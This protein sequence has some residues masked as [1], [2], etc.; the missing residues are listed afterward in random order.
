MEIFLDQ[1]FRRSLFKQWKDYYAKYEPIICSNL[2]LYANE[3]LFRVNNYNNAHVSFL[4]ELRARKETFLLFTKICT[5]A[6]NDLEKNGKKIN[7]NLEVQDLLNPLFLYFLDDLLNRVNINPENVNFE[8]LENEEINEENKSIVLWKLKALSEIWFK[9]SIDDLFSWYS[10]KERIDFLLCEDIDLSMVKIDWR[11]MQ[12]MF[13]CNKYRFDCQWVKQSLSLNDIDDF[14]K[15]V[16][17]L[18]KVWIKVVSERVETEDMLKF[19][20][21]LWIEYF[22]WYLFQ[23]FDRWEL[24]KI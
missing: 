5:K 10:S 23:W 2:E 14:K 8:I 13:L 9:I 24:F 17:D 6:F 16:S 7:I 19:A 21:S 12:E 15:Y 1:S 20:K 3:I 11:F 22:Q 18:K 4:S